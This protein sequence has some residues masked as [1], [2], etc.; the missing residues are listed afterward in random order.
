MPPRSDWSLAREGVTHDT[1]GRLIK[2]TVLNP[3][4]TLPLILL[5]RYTTRGNILA[6]Q[7]GTFFKHL[8]TIVGLGLLR[9]ISAWLDDAVT[10]NWNNDTY[11]WSQEVVVV[12]GGSDGIGKI[13][14]QLFAE[15]GIKV[16]VLDVQELTYEAPPSVRY[17]H[18]DLS[19]P[20]S[21]ASA[22]SKVRS[23][24]GNPTVLINNAGVAR[25]R[26]ILDSTEKDINLTFK[27]NAFAH[28]YLA[29]EF[30]PHMVKN[31]HGMVVTVASLAGYLVAPSMVDYASSKAAAITFHEGLAAEL[32][33]HYKAPKVRTVLMCQGYTRTAL[34]EGFAGKAL[35]PETVADEIVKAV[36]AGKSKHMTLP[37][38]AWHIVPRV[39]S[40]PLWMQYGMRKKISNLMANWKGRQVVQPSEVEKKDGGEG[41]LGEGEQKVDGSTVL[42]GA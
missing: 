22:A 8:K 21:I 23:T 19:S 38:T 24:L 31:N 1:L 40:L 6:E 36:L 25:G 27:V 11:V 29:H 33:T 2:Y 20:S 18:C 9:S 30:L 34:F 35:Y 16:A 42:V 26:T 14:V 4:L 7:H 12:T 39:R 10:N 5:G 32:V 37:E 3:A 28:Y 13:V 41:L 15:R 17:F